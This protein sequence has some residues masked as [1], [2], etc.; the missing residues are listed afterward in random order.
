MK[1]NVTPIIDIVFLLIIFFLVVCQFIEA[2]NFPVSVPDACVYSEK[3][4]EASPGFTTVTVLQEEDEKFC[5]AVGSQKLG[6][7]GSSK[8]AGQ[9]TGLIN[10]SIA[11][12]P[13]EHRVVTL[14]ID[15]KIP[16]GQ[17]QYALKAVAESKAEDIQLAVVKQKRRGGR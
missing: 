3:Q 6:G 1:T 8:L 7:P 11:V 12:A 16:Y 17:A 5:F 9:I 14:R 4:D 15:S 13:P 2:E 10:K